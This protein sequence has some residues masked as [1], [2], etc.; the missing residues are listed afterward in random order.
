MQGMLEEIHK[1]LP[2]LTTYILED[3]GA[4]GF[5]RRT[6]SISVTYGYAIMG[7]YRHRGE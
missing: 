1:R 3:W 2:K 5:G 6:G 4:R 7:F